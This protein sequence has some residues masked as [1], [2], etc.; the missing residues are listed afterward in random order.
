MSISYYITSNQA[1]LHYECHGRASSSSFMSRESGRP[2]QCT[3]WQPPNDT[4][5]YLTSYCIKLPH[6][7]SYYIKPPHLISYYIKPPCIISGEGQGPQNAAT[8]PSRPAERPSSPSHV[9][10]TRPL[11]LSLSA[12]SGAATRPPCSCGG[13]RARVAAG[14]VE[15]GHEGRV[16]GSKRL[17]RALGEDGHPHHRPCILYI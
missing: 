13:S 7:T 12:R 1:V 8:T 16:E 9:K 6:L 11:S 3:T 17:R 14:D 4:P 10:G 5:P 15:E 2:R